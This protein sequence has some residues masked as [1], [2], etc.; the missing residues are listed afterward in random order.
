LYIGP[1][2]LKIETKIFGFETGKTEIVASRSK[3]GR[4]SDVATELRRL[5]SGPRLEPR[6]H[7]IENKTNTDAD[8]RIRSQ[9]QNLTYLSTTSAEHRDEESSELFADEAVDEK[10]DGRVESQEDVCD[11]V[12]VAVV[13]VLQRR[14][15]LHR[16][17]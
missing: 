13:V 12:H 10:I 16:R 4:N 17:L 11:G 14:A 15:R 1:Q 7:T 8:T 2:N 6:S 5:I 3:L 9:D